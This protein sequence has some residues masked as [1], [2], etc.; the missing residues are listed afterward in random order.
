MA[1]EA[2]DPQRRADYEKEQLTWLQLVKEIESSE[3][4][5]PKSKPN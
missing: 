3:E 1:K 2:T 4:I 5:K